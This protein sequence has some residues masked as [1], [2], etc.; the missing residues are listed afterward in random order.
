ML[1]PPSVFWGRDSAPCSVPSQPRA[2]GWCEG[3]PG[4]EDPGVRPDDPGTVLSQVP[5]MPGGPGGAKGHGVGSLGGGA[6]LGSP[7]AGVQGGWC[8][9]LLHWAVSA[10]SP[11]WQPAGSWGP[12]PQ[13]ALLLSSS[14][15]GSPGESS[16]SLPCLDTTPLESESRCP[17]GSQVR[18]PRGQGSHAT[19]ML[20]GG[21]SPPR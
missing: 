6:L 9:V 21:H 1:Y 4:G 13:T 14:R 2:R 8:R 16:K 5:G 12:R 17:P 18:V 7:G 11:A 20:G 15:L 19:S 3:A 10:S